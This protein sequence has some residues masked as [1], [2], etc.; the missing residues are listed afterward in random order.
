M[1]QLL[2]RF[3]L[4]AIKFNWIV[5][6]ILLLL[7][8]AILASTVSSIRSQPYSRRQRNFWLVIVIC[9]PLFGVLAYLPF[10]FKKEDLPFIF[11]ARKKPKK[12]RGSEAAISNESD[13]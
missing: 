8:L 1:L 7:W 3:N 10:S 12:R 4:R 9:I 6:V 2:Q 5:V 13:V 11:Q